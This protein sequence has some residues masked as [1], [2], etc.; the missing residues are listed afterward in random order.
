MWS[1]NKHTFAKGARGWPS[2]VFASSR[3]GANVLVDQ[4]FGTGQLMSIGAY[5]E[6]ARFI[7]PQLQR[8]SNHVLR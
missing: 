5:F 8:E 1:G 7:L 3:K 6:R 4:E 2:C